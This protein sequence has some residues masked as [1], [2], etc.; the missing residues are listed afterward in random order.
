[1]KETTRIPHGLY[2]KIYTVEILYTLIHTLTTKIIWCDNMRTHPSKLYRPIC[3]SVASLH[4]KTYISQLQCEYILFFSLAVCLFHSICF[5]Y[6]MSMWFVDRKMVL[7]SANIKLQYSTENR[8]IDQTYDACSNLFCVYLSALRM[9]NKCSG[10]FHSIYWQ[11][12]TKFSF[13]SL[14][15]CINYKQFSIF[16]GHSM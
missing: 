7:C 10:N 1:M 2:V 12:C 9:L 3:C 6:T 5:V 14:K 4:T 13:Y 8:L 15:F 11:Q 16:F